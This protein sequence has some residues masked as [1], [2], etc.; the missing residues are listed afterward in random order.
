M[1]QL[2]FTGENVLRSVD[3]LEAPDP[4]WS[5]AAGGDGLGSG[6]GAAHGGDARDPVRNGAAADGLLVGEGVA[7][8]CRVDDQFQGAGFEEI[9]GV[10]TSLVDFENGF[11]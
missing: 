7:A 9:D 2:T 8:C 4:D 5:F 10:G 3:F 11:D 6:L 1:C